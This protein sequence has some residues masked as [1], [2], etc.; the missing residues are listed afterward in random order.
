MKWLHYPPI[1]SQVVRTEKKLVAVLK[2]IKTSKCLTFIEV[3]LALTDHNKA[4][5]GW[6]TAMADYNAGK[7]N[8]D[9]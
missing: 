4:L 7:D 5:L 2:K 8:A 3:I 9:H 6:G 1:L